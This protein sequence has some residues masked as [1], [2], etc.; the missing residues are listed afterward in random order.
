MKSALI[1]ALLFII[2]NSSFAEQLWLHDE[3]D[4]LELVIDVTDEHPRLGLEFSASF[5]WNEINGVRNGWM[6]KSNVGLI[7]L[8][9]SRE[10]ALRVGKAEVAEALFA[11]EVYADPWEGEMAFLFPFARTYT[12]ELYAGM[13]ASMYF[14]SQNEYDSTET[15]PSLLFEAGMDAL[16]N[17]MEWLRLRFGVR[18]HLGPEVADLAFTVG[19]IFSI[20]V[21]SSCGS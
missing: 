5:G 20:G 6:Y 3:E 4:N 2:P 14:L 18:S 16:P 8:S 17:N 15:I 1:T 10:F 9:E 19:T 21:G 7:L 12:M 13:G 11:G